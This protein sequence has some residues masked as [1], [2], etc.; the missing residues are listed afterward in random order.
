MS[1]AHTRK[2]TIGIDYLLK[3]RL[4]FLQENSTQ[5]KPRKQLE[6]E[7]RQFFV[8][9][10][11]GKNG[12]QGYTDILA[13]DVNSLNV[14]NELLIDPSFILDLYD[15]S[16][17][18]TIWELVHDDENPPM[19]SNQQFDKLMQ[20]EGFFESDT[21]IQQP[22]PELVER[23]FASTAA[24]RAAMILANAPVEDALDPQESFQILQKP[25][26]IPRPRLA[27]LENF[28]QWVRFKAKAMER[29]KAAKAPPAQ[30]RSSAN[31]LARHPD[32]SSPVKPR[33]AKVKLQMG[34]GFD[35]LVDAP[36]TLTSPPRRLD[37]S[38]P[39][40]SLIKLPKAEPLQKTSLQSHS[41]ALRILA[42]IT[43]QSLASSLNEGN[44]IA[45]AALKHS[46]NYDSKSPGRLAVKI[47]ELEEESRTP[48]PEPEPTPTQPLLQQ[49]KQQRSHSAVPRQTILQKQKSALTVPDE[50][51]DE[52]DNSPA[53]PS[54][55][56][57]PGIDDDDNVNI[58]DQLSHIVS[59][60]S[61]RPSDTTPKQ[62][63]EEK[64]GVRAASAFARQLSSNPPASENTAPDD[65][66][67]HAPHSLKVSPAALA[68]EPSS[69]PV[70]QEPATALDAKATAVGGLSRS[71][72]K[73]KISTRSRQVSARSKPHQPVKNDTMAT[74]GIQVVKAS[75][76]TQE[77]P[78]DDVK[79][80]ARRVPETVKHEELPETEVEKDVPVISVPT[81]SVKE[82]S[83]TMKSPTVRK[84]HR[85]VKSNVSNTSTSKRD[86]DIEAKKARTKKKE[87]TSV[88]DSEILPFQ[89]VP[90]KPVEKKPVKNKVPK[91]IVP[92]QPVIRKTT[93]GVSSKPGKSGPL[94]HHYD[95]PDRHL[96]NSQ[97]YGR[98]RTRSTQSLI[99]LRP[100][101][102]YKEK[103]EP[104]H[105]E[106]FYETLHKRSSAPNSDVE[107]AKKKRNEKKKKML[108]TAARAAQLEKTKMAVKAAAEKI[109]AKEAEKVKK[110]AALAA[111]KKKPV[112]QDSE[113]S[114]DSSDDDGMPI[115]RKANS[116]AV[117]RRRQH[118]PEGKSP[119]KTSK[120]LANPKKPKVEKVHEKSEK[121]IER[122]KKPV[123]KETAKNEPSPKPIVANPTPKP[124]KEKP[125]RIIAVKSFPVKPKA[126]SPVEVKRE[127][128]P[129]RQRIRKH[130][131]KLGA[132]I[133]DVLRV[134]LNTNVKDDLELP[135]APVVDEAIQNVLR[136]EPFVIGQTGRKAISS[137]NLAFDEDA[138]E[139]NP[140]TMSPIQTETYDDE[141]P[142]T[143]AEYDFDEAD[144]RTP[145][146][147]RLGISKKPKDKTKIQ[148]SK[149]DNL[150]IEEDEY[151]AVFSRKPVMV[152]SNVS[153]HATAS[154]EKEWEIERSR[155]LESLEESK[156]TFS[157]IVRKKRH[158]Y[159]PVAVGKVVVDVTAIFLGDVVVHEAYVP[160][161][162]SC[163]LDLTAKRTVFRTLMYISDWTLHYSQRINLK[164][165]L[166]DSITSSRLNP[167]CIHIGVVEGLPNT[168]V[169][170]KELDAKCVKTYTKFKFFEDTHIHRANSTESSHGRKASINAR[171]VIL[172]GLMDSEKLLESLTN[173]LL[174]IEVHDRDLSADD[175]SHDRAN[176]FGVATF[177][178]QNPRFANYIDRPCRIDS[179]C[180]SF[181]TVCT[182]FAGQ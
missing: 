165:K 152:K 168:P 126:T 31:L 11:I 89:L 86:P 147:L 27:G 138:I 125:E 49:D 155:L 163:I 96:F 24:S 127:A 67:K 176:A 158:E 91:K 94:P 44:S 107:G 71:S 13:F 51:A 180:N 150:D 140:D 37:P 48:E 4:Q 78:L 123:K 104:H 148:K 161:S 124:K 139:A 72:S 149:D 52:V 133:N 113:E 33:A 53:P 60:R 57:I 146:R 173:Q 110:A 80:F 97:Q 19:L 106:H 111:T 22:D 76:A 98:R 58:L 8:S 105:S 135:E 132:A 154:L 157:N 162:S 61:R 10:K 41:N 102:Y 172:P 153:R 59:D 66:P 47:E 28:D 63:R 171:H 46:N 77:P 114:G 144:L 82:K 129:P 119:N 121:T 130:Q 45:N 88:S 36:N 142:S 79:S 5:K 159:V 21:V 164:C 90:K 69:A 62:K 118:T 26:S 20:K 42:Q 169:S 75:D 9:Y 40:K 73:E 109:A 103:P 50:D 3:K 182:N 167:M 95:I 143:Y 100:D 81:Q 30:S 84:K 32:V 29:E 16:V 2:L 56:N 7:Y 179:W 177:S 93:H 38:Q 108:S 166:R 23:Q 178:M 175:E 160:F 115:V 181:G 87:Q 64:D 65:S 92:V 1:N 120:K 128:P 15:H 25:P 112:L 137:N 145:R 122:V 141:E 68:P 101:I 83:D 70:I 35:E 34:L 55:V 174:Q 17:Q 12:A 116:Q 136:S 43:A 131:V 151:E 39:S 54:A 99:R 85:R 117:M 156:P 170:Y 134:D 74:P 18:V 6:R 14:C